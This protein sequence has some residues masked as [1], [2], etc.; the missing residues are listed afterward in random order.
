M[1][2]SCDIEQWDINA[3]TCAESMAHVGKLVDA[4]LD[5]QS[6]ELAMQALKLCD[7]LKG[8]QLSDAEQAELFYF[9]ANAWSSIRDAKHSSSGDVWAWDQPELL[10]EAYC[11]RT[12]IRHDGFRGLGRF[13]QCQIL[14]NAG[15]L[16]S[17]IG[18]PIEAIEYWRRALL[19]MPNFAMALGNLGFGLKAYARYLYDNGHAVVLMKVAYDFLMSVS[20]HGVVW[21]GLGY[22]GIRESMLGEAK[23]I[24]DHVNLDAARSIELNGHSLGRSKTER[25]YRVWALDNTLFLSPL[26]EL[27]DYSIAAHDI[28]SLPDMVAPVNKPPSLIG[29]YNQLKQE[30]TSARFL[31]WEGVADNKAHF[32]DRDVQLLD[33]LDYP[34]YSLQ[35]EKMKMAYRMAYSIFDKIAF[36]INEYW[37]L[38]MKERA[39]N[40]QS[41]WYSRNDKKSKSKK[42]RTNFSSYQNLSLRGLFWLSKDLLEDSVE[43]SPSDSELPNLAET[44]EPDA[45]ALR[46]IRNHL[47]HKYLKVHD[48]LWN[49]SNKYSHSSFKDDMAY[50][51]TRDSLEAKT[52]RLIKMA[53]AGLIYLSL[54]VH[55]EEAIRAEKRQD[56]FVMPM[57]LPE[58]RGF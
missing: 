6:P 34:L 8:L 19:I 11:L 48:E 26:N 42:I 14:T 41:I 50:S 3:H 35:I 39:I 9:R 54:A 40:F 12:A 17:H 56:E 45:Y 37:A 57:R 31:L 30:Y 38:G 25:N 4:S 1:S 13:R 43:Q 2:S 28:L 18:R 29:F 22:E 49:I 5:E 23:D 24:A 15:N 7:E 47:E 46:T 53:R 55:R 58:W 52:L 32:S 27:G 33:T 21:D 51:L 44:M 10:H 20:K 16:F 36:F